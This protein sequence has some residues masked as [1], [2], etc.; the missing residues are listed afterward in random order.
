MSFSGFAGLSEHYNDVIMARLRLKSPASRSF[1]QPFI[2]AEIKKTSKLRVTGLCAGNSP[3]P[4]NSPH[5]WPVTLKMFPFDDVIMVSGWWCQQQQLGR[6]D[7]WRGVDC[8]ICYDCQ[9]RSSS[10]IP[11]AFRGGLII[12]LRGEIMTRRRFEEPSAHTQGISRRNLLSLRMKE[13][14]PHQNMSRRSPCKA[15][16]RNC[17]PAD[18]WGEYQEY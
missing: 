10:R 17:N 9:W 14:F 4:V 13:P 3:G 2:Q 12:W 7:P 11:K 6:H 16:R 1:T 18:I 5:K 15:S 8:E